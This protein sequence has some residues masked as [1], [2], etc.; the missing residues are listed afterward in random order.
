[1]KV[2]TASKQ[3][4][5]LDESPAFIEIVTQDDIKR[6][7]YKDLSYLLDDIAGVQVTRSFSDN[8]FNTLWRGVRHT[9]GSSYLILVDGIKFNHLYNNETEILATFPL[10][11]IKQIEIV[12]GPA[13]VTYGNDAVV[14]IINV[15]TNKNLKNSEVFV[16][17]GENNK[18]VIDFTTFINIKNYQLRITGRYDQ[19]SLDLSNGDNYR[20]TN[21]ELLSNTSIWGYFSAQYGEEK[22]EHRNK[23]L[24][25]ITA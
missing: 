15:I 21:T 1:M 4:Q 14:G 25:P 10:S 6:R 23:A 7:G 16:Q 11:N 17:L 12:H 8:Y 13:S 19:G 3:E 22:S 9:I 5:S 2:S 24:S 20:W 18:Q